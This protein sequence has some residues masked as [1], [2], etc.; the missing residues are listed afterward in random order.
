MTSSFLELLDPKRPSQQSSGPKA[1]TQAYADTALRNAVAEMRNAPDGQRNATLNIKAFAMRPFVTAAILDEQYVVDSLTD[2]A[3][4]AGLGDFEIERTIRSGFTGSDA[5]NRPR[6]VLEATPTM[7]GG[8]TQEAPP[9]V[10]NDVWGDLP[11]VDG[12]SWMFDYDD[13]TIALWGDGDDILWA[14]GEAL[15]IAGGMGLGKTTM[16]GRL[17]RGMLGLD[18]TVLNLPIASV[19]KPILYLA[20]DRPRQIR[21][22]FRRQFGL[23][24]QDKIKGRLIIRPGPPIADLAVQPQ[25]LYRMA[26]AAGAGTVFVDSLK[27]AVVGLSEDA[28]AAAYNRARQTAL[29]KGVQICE[30]H[31]TRKTT[32]ESTG[33]I[34]EVFGS[35][36]LTAGAGSVIMLSGEPGDPIIRFRH[37][38]VPADEVGPWR[39]HHDPDAGYL[40]VVEIDMLAVV[41]NAGPDGATARFAAQEWYETSSPNDSQCK[42]AQ[43]KLDK[44]VKRGL[45][46]RVDGHRG[47]ARGSTPICWFIAPEIRPFT[48]DDGF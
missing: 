23:K 36:W 46:T 9:L 42:K 17:I 28:T 41:A 13:K 39:L 47:G 15:M 5:E 40:E 16:A 3:R 48:E 35:T 24:D 8:D 27:D 34:G 20:M 45:L 32:K 14:E 2:A 44:L 11:P 12:A 30:L 31:H 1:V 38:K 22:S 6:Y 33:G 7:P 37:V 43:R 10:R 18:T 25:L 4:A 26:E 21:R 19:D 29:A